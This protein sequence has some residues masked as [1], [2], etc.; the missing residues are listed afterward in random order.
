MKV[1]VILECPGLSYH[2]DTDTLATL[3]GF[4]TVLGW[5]FHEAQWR[6]SWDQAV[7]RGQNADD[8]I[9]H[10]MGDIE[11]IYTSPDLAKTKDLLSKYNVDYVYIGDAERQKYQANAG[12]L[13]KFGQLGSTPFMRKEILCCTR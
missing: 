10:R 11:S 9:Q 4:P 1:P 3:T 8:T 5:D 6:G 2:Q 12:A 13:V 7:I